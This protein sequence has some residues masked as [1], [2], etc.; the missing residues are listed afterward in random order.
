MEILFIE[1][2][3]SR[4]HFSQFSIDLILRFTSQFIQ[5]DLKKYVI[6]SSLSYIN[7]TL[8]DIMKKNRKQL[9]NS[10]HSNSIHLKCL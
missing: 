2:L 4:I 7:I 3:F 1:I 9:K 8:L 5:Y 10:Y 6:L